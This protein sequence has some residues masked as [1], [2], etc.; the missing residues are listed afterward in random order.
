MSSPALGRLWGSCGGGRGL[1]RKARWARGRFRLLLALGAFGLGSAAWGQSGLVVTYVVT[2]EGNWTTAST[3]GGV[4][5]GAHF[6]TW[7]GG[8]HDAGVSFW[9][10]GETASPGIEAMAETGATGGLRAEIVASP[11]A[12][13]VIR[14][15]VAGGGTG[16]ATFRVEVTASH[17]LVTLTSMIGPSPDWFVG[18]S[19]LSLLDDRQ[20][21]Y[22]EQRVDL[23]PYDAGTEDGTE[24]SLS[25]PDTRPRGVIAGIRGTGKFSAEPMA[26]LRF[27]LRL[28]R[29]TG[30]TVTA[31]EGGLAVS[32]DAVPGADGYRVQWR[33]GAEEFDATREH[34]VA[35]GN[36]TGRVIA[37][38]P[39][40]IEYSVRV[41]ATRGDVTG[42]PSEV[43]TGTP[44]DDDTEAPADG[45]LR[46]IFSG[47]DRASVDLPMLFGRRDAATYGAASSAPGL[48]AVALDGQR[49]V[50]MSARDASAGVATITVTATDAEG[51]TAATSFCVR[52][53]ARP[54]G[55]LRGWR[56]VL[57][58][59]G[60]GTDP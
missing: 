19:G 28:G 49:L 12:V 59:E 6:T 23:F 54:P 37:G 35:G 38:L 41:V 44:S 30:V 56:G 4:V 46:E 8:I 3:P 45:P 15:P 31:D 2:F 57:F 55:V 47:G 22:G 10:S 58:R 36:V 60:D 16:G 51:R 14:Q 34:V 27:V 29:V 48:V 11:H 39:P 32:W 13:A 21:W 20:A 5:G 17:P 25:N 40:G 43:A 52:V 53:T 50:L 42:P 7:I 26:R 24:F 9:R 33:S 1:T 18:I